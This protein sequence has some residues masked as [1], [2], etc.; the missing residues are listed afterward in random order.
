MF[1]CLY[2]ARNVSILKSDYL[3]KQFSQN[4][5]TRFVIQSVHVNLTVVCSVL[6]EWISSIDWG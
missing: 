6:Q 4:L 5:P 1:L 2:L 3:K